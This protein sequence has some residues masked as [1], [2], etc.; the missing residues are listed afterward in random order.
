[1]KKIAL[2][3][4]IALAALPAMA[5]ANEQSPLAGF[6]VGVAVTHDS[7]KVALP[8]DVITAEENGL[9][10]TGFAGY[11]AVVG[12]QFLVG[13]Q[14]ELGTGGKTAGALLG[15]RLASYYVD[16]GVSYAFTA[17]AGILASDNIA[18][19]GRL[20][21]RSLRANIAVMSP[22]GV[23]VV[24]R[25][26]ESGLTYGA[27]AEYALSSSLSVRAE[28]ARTNFDKGISQNKLAVGAALR[29]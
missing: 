21:V 23:L 16:P 1:M 3:S 4:A 14:V 5:Q 10:V 28:Y 18:V 12:G 15:D 19:Y 17:R 6:N 11:D 20:G 27:G 25:T 29:F 9:G 2:A 13:G 8:G 22:T 7:N 24:G 26:T